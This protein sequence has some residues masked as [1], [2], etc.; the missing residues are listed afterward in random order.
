MEKIGTDHLQFNEIKKAPVL[1]GKKLDVYKRFHGLKHANDII[2]RA[3]D[4]LL[5][6]CIIVTQG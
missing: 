6:D 4:E 3:L 5:A 2:N 1:D